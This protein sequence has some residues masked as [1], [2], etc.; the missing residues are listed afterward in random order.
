MNRP[1]KLVGLAETLNYLDRTHSLTNGVR[2]MILGEHLH[3][4]LVFDWRS[5]GYEWWVVYS[6]KYNHSGIQEWEDRASFTD[7][8]QACKE[9]TKRIEAQ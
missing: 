1:D 6:V 5:S 4:V 8:Y 9:F 2:G 3:T 7:I